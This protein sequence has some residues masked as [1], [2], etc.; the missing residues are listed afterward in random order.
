[1]LMRQEAQMKKQIMPLDGRLKPVQ[2]RAID[3]VETILTTAAILLDE[4]GLD[5][6]NT[7]LLAERAGVRV[8]TVYRYFPN[9]YAVIIALTEVLAVQWD[10]WM[11]RCYQDLGN[12]KMSWKSALRAARVGWFDSAKRVP[13]AISVLQAM[14]ATPELK[15]LHF[16]IFDDM[17][18]KVAAAL[19][20]R[21]LRLP[22]AKLMAIGRTVVSAMNTGTEVLLRLGGPEAKLFVAELDA[23]QEAYLENYLHFGA[24]TTA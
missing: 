15:D 23:S 12:P 8:R 4:V 19:R 11:Q 16:R 3:S 1:M 6:F 13:G 7:N 20:A 24:S 10:R 14:H 5:G 18:R 22:Q 2:Q 17:S 9:K 21:G